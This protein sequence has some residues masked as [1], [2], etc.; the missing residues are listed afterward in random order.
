MA[1][2]TTHGIKIIHSWI[3]LDGPGDTIEWPIRCFQLN[4]LGSANFSFG[5][6]SIR[7]TDQTATRAKD[8][9]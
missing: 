8:R 2:S 4:F 9:T 3:Y 6:V 7:V 5:L 1:M